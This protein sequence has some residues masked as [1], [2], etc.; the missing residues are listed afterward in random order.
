MVLDNG[1]L[2]EHLQVSWLYGRNWLCHQPYSFPLKQHC[3]Y[4]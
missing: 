4:K 3:P 1:L 2:V